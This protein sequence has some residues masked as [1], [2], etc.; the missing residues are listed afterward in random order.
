MCV[1]TAEP[2]LLAKLV[3]T[4]READESEWKCLDHHEEV[5][6]RVIEYH[7]YDREGGLTQKNHF[8]GGRCVRV[9]CLPL[10][11]KVLMPHMYIYNQA[12]TRLRPCW[13]FE[14]VL[15]F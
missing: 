12:P 5:N 7:H 15:V 3:G 4:M 2:E 8:D 9:Q 1:Q 6:V 13:V 11:L 10:R 14:E